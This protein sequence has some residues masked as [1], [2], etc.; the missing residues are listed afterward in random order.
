MR[1]C[2][3][4]R[5]LQ[6]FLSG[7]RQRLL[8]PIK[9]TGRR[10]G[11]K[12]HRRR[13]KTQRKGISLHVALQVSDFGLLIRHC[14]NQSLNF[15]GGYPFPL[16]VYFGVNGRRV[17]ANYGI[18]AGCEIFVSFGSQPAICAADFYRRRFVACNSG[19]NNRPYAA[20]SVGY[21]AVVEY[22]GGAIVV[23]TQGNAA[24]T[25][26]EE[27]AQRVFGLPKADG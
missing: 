17:L 6:I 18:G 14:R 26:F 24:A 23:A 16:Q 8:T 19:D 21:G 9:T 1:V 20:F 10:Y 13:L 25:A 22:R 27:A 4:D 12:V 5:K 11:D 2:G 7:D 3:S 15:G